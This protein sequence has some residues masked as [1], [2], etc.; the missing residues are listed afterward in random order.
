M[1]GTLQLGR[2][3]AVTGD[4]RRPLALDYRDWVLADGSAGSGGSASSV[5]IRYFLS[6]ERRFRIRPR[7]PTDGRPIPVIASRSLAD[8]AGDAAVVP[9]RVGQAELRARIVATAERFPTLRGDFLIADLKAV[10]TAANAVVPGTAVPDE[11]WLRGPPGEQ[12]ALRAVAP[13]PVRVASRD[14]LERALRADSVSRGVSL[15]LLGAALLAAAL[16]IVGLLL[17]IAVD[18]RDNRPELFDLETVGVAPA[19]LARH[20][21]L[22]LAL[23]LAAGLV[24]GLV[25]GVAM[26]FLV[27]D[28]V[29]VTANLTAAE[30]P[31]RTVLDWPLLVAGL[32]LFVF[33]AL[34]ATAFLAR[35]QFREAAPDRP[36]AA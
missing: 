9:I 16:A 5:R 34:A 4:G 8:A 7:Q 36:S 29:A 15:A 10:E 26:V 27:T 22:R 25:T 12:P 11:V 32:A 3:F 24:A 13:L 6:Q 35:A 18:V 14:A 31:L 21:W 1:R 19:G 28:V 17:T 23:V 20:V 33:A 2:P 30:P